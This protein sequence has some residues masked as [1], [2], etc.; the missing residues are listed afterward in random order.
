VRTLSLDYV[1]PSI[2]YAGTTVGLFASR[3]GGAR[4]SRLIPGVVVNAIVVHPTDDRIVLVGTDDAGVLRTT[5]G[6]QSFEPVNNGF[7]HRQVTDLAVS[8]N[9][10]ALYAAIALDR[11]YG[12][13]FRSVDNGH[14]WESYNEGLDQLVDSVTC[15]LTLDADTVVI[16]TRQG[17]LVGNPGEKPWNLIA[18]TK[19]LRVLDLAA[20]P[21]PDIVYIAAETG[22]LELSLKTQKL[23]QLQI[24]VYRGKI[25]TV[26][27]DRESGNLFA[28][29]DTGVFRSGDGGETWA[30]KVR[31]L[32]Y[33]PI[34]SLEKSSL[35]ILCGTKQGVFVTNNSGELWAGGKG[36]FPL[37]IVTIT[38]NPSNRSEVFAADVL[39]GY[40]FMSRDGG[41]SWEVLNPLDTRSRISSL[42]FGP[43]GKLFAGT[44]SEGIYLIEELPPSQLAEGAETDD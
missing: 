19:K 21:E 22:I 32:P 6:G 40:L 25:N 18:S 38:A 30:M 14:S 37:D 36:I 27:F 16:G 11:H 5:D 31:G 12:G 7:S 29:G 39:V 8:P 3:D 26:L 24:P 28:G 41:M 9:G 42:A 20:G 44:L 10:E 13:F 35:G 33:S 15:I 17:V 43:D 1:N 2:I 34:H 4:W 23:R